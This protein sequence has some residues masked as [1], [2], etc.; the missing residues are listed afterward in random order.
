MKQDNMKNSSVICGMPQQ[1]PILHLNH[2]IFL[3]DKILLKLSI[4]V[5]KRCL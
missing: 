3:N 2:R 5:T 4:F 1:F